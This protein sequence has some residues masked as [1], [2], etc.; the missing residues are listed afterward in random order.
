MSVSFPG[1]SDFAS[2]SWQLLRAIPARSDDRAAIGVRGGWC[3]RIWPVL[4]VVLAV[5]G[6]A[7][8]RAGDWI[9]DYDPGEWLIV[10]LEVSRGGYL[11]PEK[12]AVGCSRGALFAERYSPAGARP[13]STLAL[14]A[15]GSAA[16][17]GTIV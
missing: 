12:L 6:T 15:T 16:D 11:E 14:S 17:E 5:A 9:A 1:V 2:P 10:A 3:A 13:R 7:P 8:A 4:I